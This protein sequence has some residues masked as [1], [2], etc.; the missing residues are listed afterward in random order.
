MDD[1]K[2]VIKTYCVTKSDVKKM[3]KYELDKANNHLSILQEIADGN[4][5]INMMTIQSRMD[6]GGFF[7]ADEMDLIVRAIINVS[8]ESMLE[9]LHKKIDTLNTKVFEEE[10]EEREDF[11][12]NDYIRQILES[13]GLKPEDVTITRVNNDTGEEHIINLD[14]ED[15]NN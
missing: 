5:D 10:I 7:N 3:L 2:K 14:D 4:S 8:N 13:N 6:Y 1:D 12:E 11:S 9:E 15:N